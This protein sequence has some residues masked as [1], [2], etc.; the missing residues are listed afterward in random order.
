MYGSRYLCHGVVGLVEHG[1]CVSHWW[2]A[3]QPPPHCRRHR[4]CMTVDHPCLRYAIVGSVRKLWTESVARCCVILIV[5]GHSVA[6]GWRFALVEQAPPLCRH[7]V[8]GI[9]CS[10]QLASA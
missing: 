5:V 10:L 2:R 9:T 1:Y 8:V 3:T 7:I 4:W 6:S